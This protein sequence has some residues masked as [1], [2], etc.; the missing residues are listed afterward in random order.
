MPDMLL[1]VTPAR[2]SET[3]KK[4]LTFSFICCAVCFFAVHGYFISNNF[5]N[6]DSLKEFYGVTL[7]NDWKIEL[8][9]V[10]V[11]LYRMLFRTSYTPVWLIGII[12][13]LF[14]SLTL[15]LLIRLFDVKSKTVA[16][17]IAVALISNNTITSL[18]ATYIHDMDSYILALLCAVFSVYVWKN[19]KYG[20]VYG[21]LPNVL[22]LGIYQSYISVTI[23]LIMMVSMLRLLRRESPAN[24]CVMG[25]CSIA[26]LA[27]SGLI[28][29]LCLK[30]IPPMMGIDL[31]ANGRNAILSE[32]PMDLAA[33]LGASLQGIRDCFSII[34]DSM[35]SVPQTVS[36]TVNGLVVTAMVLM[37]AYLS[38]VNKLSWKHIGL[39]LLLLCA[40]PFAMNL[41][42]ILAQG[43]SHSL[44][45]YAM[46]L[47]YVFALLLAEACWA[48]MGPVKALSAASCLLV[49]MILW[50][51]V[52]TANVLYM[53]RTLEFNST[54]M[55]FNR[56][57]GDLEEQD[58]YT[59]RESKIIF[60]GSQRDLFSTTIDYSRYEALAGMSINNSIGPTEPDFFRAYF[61]YVLRYPIHLVEDLEQWQSISLDP[62][63]R[64][65]P[66]YPQPGY[67]QQMGDF[68]VI[69]LSN[70]IPET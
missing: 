67:I 65:M 2:W 40:A 54:Q 13:I 27:V 1:Q 9:R 39:L 31:V 45:D 14:F 52:I 29:V 43:F 61:D 21:I 42:Q 26:M 25:L 15:F 44:M 36:F 33:F 24:V 6:H 62:A 68:I 63:V 17:L 7:G 48:R 22:L 69:K 66:R 23:V 11:P 12:S 49:V 3:A 35:K 8:G 10:F 55:A 20:F 19:Y 58:F 34:L 46:W 37:L 18:M 16:A 5:I 28:Y 70:Y 41:A 47:T 64:E 57:L 56:I 53:K 50:N 51:N 30:Y 32:N 38:V 60:A 4:Q 59:Y